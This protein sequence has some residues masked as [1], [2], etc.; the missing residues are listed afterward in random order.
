[1]GLESRLEKMTSDTKNKLAELQN[2]LVNEVHQKTLLQ[3]QIANYQYTQA[4]L[5]EKLKTSEE[6]CNSLLMK[7]ETNQKL[8]R[9]L[10]NKIE[11]L[12]KS[13]RIIEEEKNKNRLLEEQVVKLKNDHKVDELKKE[14]KREKD[15]SVVLQRQIQVNIFNSDS[16]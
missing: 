13:T 1:M 15:A 14:L 6:N 11:I 8:I 2:K 5:K 4:S 9:E 16:H 3:N 7:L 10:E 12:E